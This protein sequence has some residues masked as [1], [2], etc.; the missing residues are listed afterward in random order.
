M[1]KVIRFCVLIV[2]CLTLS[3]MKSE[4]EKINWITMDQLNELYYK[5]PKPILI[6][7]YT[8]WCGWCKEMDRTTYQNQ[9]LVS[10]INTRYYAVRLNAEST[11]SLVFNRKK[12]GYNAHDRSNALAEYLL[13]NRMEFPTTVFLASMDAQPAPLP[14]YMKPKEMEAPLRFFGEGANLKQTFV[15]FNKSMKKEW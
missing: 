8:S 15:E 10:Y 2:L 12:Y 1:I 4:K 14:G 11:D 6:D 9:K 5:S 7:V 13:F 3:F